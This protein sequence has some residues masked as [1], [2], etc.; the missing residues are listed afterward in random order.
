M[1]HDMTAISVQQKLQQA[2]QSHKAGNVADAE[3]GYLQVLAMHPLHFDAL[4]LL[5]ALKAQAGDLESAERFLGAAIKANP[6]SPPAHSDYANLLL[7]LDRA[8]EALAYCDKA[9]A[10]K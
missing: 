3:R 9:L 1:L 5:G 4:R 8:D 10:L 6:Q 7:K 2:V